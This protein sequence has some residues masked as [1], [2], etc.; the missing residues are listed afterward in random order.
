MK[1]LA[2]LLL[3]ASCEAPPVFATADPPQSVTSGRIEGNVVA[4]G[5]ARGNVT[6]LLFDAARLPPPFGTGRPLTFST[7]KGDVLFGTATGNGPFSAP[8]AFSLVAPG[9]YFIG[10]LIDANADFI[11]FYSV[12]AGANAGDVSGASVDP[13]TQAPRVIAVTSATLDVGVSFSPAGAIPVDRPVFQVMGNAPSVA[14]GMAGA[15]IELGPQPIDAGAVHEPQP[16]FLA[17]LAPDGM[18]LLW[19][20]VIVRKLADPAKSL[21]IDDNDLDNNGVPDDP[22]KGVIVLAAGFDPTAIAALLVDAMGMPKTTPTPVT[23]LTLVLQQQA[24]DATDPAMPKPLPRAS[25]TGTYSIT[26]IEPTGQT[27]T[28]PNELAPPIATVVGLPALATQAFEVQVP[29]Q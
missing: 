3:L 9:N 17:Q 22:S 26:L 8:F 28:V 5:P 1:K 6:L 13:L 23:S 15:D 14:V 16:V 20:K 21:L 27:W 18:S 7:V 4:V 24:L 25:A 10:G 12:T 11:P 2:L 19:P 29:E